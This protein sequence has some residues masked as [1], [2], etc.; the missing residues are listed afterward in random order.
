VVAPYGC[1]PDVSGCGSRIG[2]V[3]LS[4]LEFGVCV[5]Q[6]AIDV[7]GF[8]RL[9]WA[10]FLAS[11]EDVWLGSS[12]VVLDGAYGS[13]GWLSWSLGR[14]SGL[15]V[16]SSLGTD[17]KNVGWWSVAF[18]PGSRYRR[19]YVKT[20][21]PVCRGEWRYTMSRVRVLMLS[22]LAVFAVA[23]VASASASALL[24]WVCL[25]G[26]GATE[27]ENNKC[28]KTKSGGGFVLQLLPLNVKLK[29]VSKGGTQVMK[30]PGLGG[31]E[32]L[33][34]TVKYKGWIEN[35]GAASNGISEIEELDFLECTVVT[36]AQ[37]PKC[38]FKKPGASAG[39]IL[40]NNLETKLVTF[41]GGGIGDLIKKVG[42]TAFVELEIGREENSSTKKFKKACGII[43]TAAQKIEG[44]VV[45]K[46]E[47][48][49]K[50]HFTEPAQEGTD[51]ELGGFTGAYVGEDENEMEGGGLL[52]ARE[53]L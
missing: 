6:L 42:S 17:W 24:W 38:E 39:L 21:A 14:K 49:G 1:A 9:I 33:C 11:F 52:E 45:A 47:A 36:P 25:S 7:S 34:K 10:G 26:T 50:L 2:R 22:L 32:L 5:S 37:S 40:I 3:A 13:W 30:V 12:I 44:Q 23:A 19:N 31:L 18:A 28:E 41:A 48:S 53:E 16:G 15:R 29:V 43:P 27:Y 4:L 35:N 46:I 8:G 51:L 20:S